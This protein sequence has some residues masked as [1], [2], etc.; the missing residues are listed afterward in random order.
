MQK[1]D[2]RAQARVPEASQA[3]AAGTCAKNAQGSRR[4]M[5]VKGATPVLRSFDYEGVM[6]ST[7]RYEVDP[8]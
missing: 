2:P 5:R 4:V 7:L 6:K 3:V 1:A 8:S